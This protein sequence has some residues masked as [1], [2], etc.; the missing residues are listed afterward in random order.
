MLW[1]IVVQIYIC[2]SVSYFVTCYG[3]SW[4]KYTLEKV[5]IS[6]KVEA[7]QEE[8]SAILDLLAFQEEEEEKEKEEGEE[9]EDGR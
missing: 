4:Y 6:A 3:T 7:L 5:G 1:Y 2:K 8:Y 9:E